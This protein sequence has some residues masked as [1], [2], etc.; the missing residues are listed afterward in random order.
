MQR[1]LHLAPLLHRRPGP[2][3]VFFLD[4]LAHGLAPVLLPTL[5]DQLE[6]A[7]RD[8]AADDKGQLIATLHDRS[9]LGGGLPPSAQLFELEPSE[10]GPRLRPNLSG[11]GS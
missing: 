10:H 6:R 4:D 2:A 3:P 7:E 9:Q 8:R 5:L 11:N 1:L